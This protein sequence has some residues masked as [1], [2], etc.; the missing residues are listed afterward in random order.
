MHLGAH[1]AAPGYTAH[2]GVQAE[3]SALGR[4]QTKS[5]QKRSTGRVEWVE[6]VPAAP[7]RTA[8]EG[9]RQRGCAGMCKGGAQ[10]EVC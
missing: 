1:M 2:E 10:V 5:V 4:P 9:H 7:G 8:Q 3:S 6:L